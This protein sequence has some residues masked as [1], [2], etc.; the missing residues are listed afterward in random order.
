MVL[1]HSEFHNLAVRIAELASGHVGFDVETNGLSVYKGAR[2]FIMGFTDEKGVKYSVYLADIPSSSL[3]LFFSNPRMKYVA[4]NAKF[5]L[6]F[7]RHQFSVEVLGMNWDSEV[8]ERLVKGS[9]PSYSLQNCALRMSMTKHV[10]ML[11]WLKK[12]G[13]KD[14][15]HGAPAELIEPYVEQ[16]AWL[17]WEL[18]RRQI[19]TFKHYDTGSRIPIHEVVKLEMEVLPHL[20]NM[21]SMGLL[22]DV[23]YCKRAI[24]YEQGKA[25]D[26]RRAFEKLTGS[27]LVNSGKALQ[28][29]F[30]RFNIP[31]ACTEL[32]NPSF[33]EDSLHASRD[34]PIVSALIGHRQ[35][36]KRV[37]T[38]WQNFI[39]LEQNG[40]IHT[41][42]NQNRAETGRMSSS[43]PNCQNW[44]TDDD[45]PEF[46]IRRAFI[47]RPGCKIVSID[48][49]QMELRMMCDEA[50]DMAMIKA[51]QEGTDFHQQVADMAGVPRSLA[52]N[53]RFA[54]LYGAGVRKVASTLGVSEALATT[55]CTAIDATSPRVA[56]YSHEL[57]RAAEKL[58]Y[59]HDWLG[60]RFHFDKGFAYKYPNFRIQ[61]GCAEILKLAIIA[62]GNLLRERASE[63]TFMLV[64]I[65]DELVFNFHPRDLHL[66]PEIKRLMIAA[67][68]SKKHLSMDVNVTIGEN[69][70]DLEEYAI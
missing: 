61:G 49:S 53:G 32:G 8:N 20:F 51:I 57:T 22:T 43:E 31:Y 6:S 10:P 39:E 37:A 16:D 65:H 35:A 55:I 30:D 14:N 62:V 40:I 59:G 18:A 2:A 29:I 63:D 33:T 46:P 68:R 38:Y 66:I 42:L 5:E 26:H 34:H 15:Y 19:E 70:H 58:T 25:E 48:Y 36:H 45:D 13:N 67:H 21:E 50:E 17:S 60:R 52:K 64:V 41:S 54:K 12:K 47:A 24:E 27:P 44:P 7:L 11:E 28:P 1:T 9:H 23:N 3:A 69:F 56:A 4:H